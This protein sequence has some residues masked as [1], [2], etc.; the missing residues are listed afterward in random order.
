MRNSFLSQR[1]WKRRGFQGPY[2]GPPR[3]LT[4][5]PRRHRVGVGRAYL[6]IGFPFDMNRLSWNSSKG[7]K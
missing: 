7:I 3:F 6:C 2:L 5:H 1:F 4:E